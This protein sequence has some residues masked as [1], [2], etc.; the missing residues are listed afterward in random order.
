MSIPSGIPRGKL[1]GRLHESYCFSANQAG[2]VAA[3]DLLS[4]CRLGF[5]G[6]NRC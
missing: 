6:S 3:T 5:L 1:H 2:Q 4:Y